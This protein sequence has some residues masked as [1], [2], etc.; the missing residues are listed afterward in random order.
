MRNRLLIS[1]A[2]VALLGG[3]ARGQQA[4]DPAHAFAW[5]ENC[6]W[7]NWTP[8]PPGGVLVR[9]TYL[10]GYIWGENIGWV[11]LGAVPPDGY[12]H[13]NTDDTDYGVNIDAAGV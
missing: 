4:I 9:T 11:H 2:G 7:I 3:A 5:G 8:G 10:S 13:G 6:G 1:F 12:Q